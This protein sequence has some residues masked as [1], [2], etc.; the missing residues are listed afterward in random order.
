MRLAAK[1]RQQS[2]MRVLTVAL[3]AQ[4]LNRRVVALPA[5]QDHQRRRRLTPHPPSTRRHHRRQ[6]WAGDGYA[7]RGAPGLATAGLFTGGFE[8]DIMRQQWSE[9]KG[10]SVFKEALLALSSRD[11]GRLSRLSFDLMIYEA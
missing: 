5:R 2:A 1:A 7:P 4:A 9:W 11:H 8:L 10:V 6:R 3:L